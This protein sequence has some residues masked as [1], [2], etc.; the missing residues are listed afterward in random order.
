[1]ADVGVE[2]F[3]H[4][5]WAN[6]RLIDACATLDEADLSATTEGTYGTVRDTLTHLVAAE[7]NYLVEFNGPTEGRLMVD[8][9]FV[10]FDKLRAYAV[11]NG[12]ALLD[13][14]S[15]KPADRVLKGNYRGEPYEMP[16]SVMLVHAINHSTEHRAHVLSILGPRGVAVGP[17]WRLDGIGYF[18]AGAHV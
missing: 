4:N 6:L 16:A 3:R 9:P 15:S 12:Q 11:A 7:G 1:M 18:Q 14:A 17:G 10:G 5:L 2:A 8:A 13:I